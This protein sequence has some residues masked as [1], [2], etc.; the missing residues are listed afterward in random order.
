MALQALVAW[1]LVKFEDNVVRAQIDTLL[2]GVTV[3]TTGRDG[4][5]DGR[6]GIDG[7]ERRGVVLPIATPN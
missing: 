3:V 7:M 6:C 2:P 1:A 4:D 5:K